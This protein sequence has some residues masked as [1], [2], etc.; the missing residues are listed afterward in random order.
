ML[1]IDTDPLTAASHPSYY[2]YINYIIVIY[3]AYLHS[4]LEAAQFIHTI[5]E[6]RYSDSGGGVEGGVFKI[7]HFPEIKVTS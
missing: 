4:P 2:N 7:R 5:M 3:G 6:E 1:P